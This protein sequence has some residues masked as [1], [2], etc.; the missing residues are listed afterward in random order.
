MEP[1]KIGDL[2]GCYFSCSQG[3]LLNAI[4]IFIKT[5]ICNPCIIENYSFFMGFREKPLVYMDFQ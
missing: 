3:F 4:H 5:L 1:A 2:K